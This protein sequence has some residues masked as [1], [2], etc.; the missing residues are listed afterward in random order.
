MRTSTLS[1]SLPSAALLAA[2]CAVPGP[3]VATAAETAPAPNAAAA[4]APG[5]DEILAR[6]AAARGG[7]DR[8]QAVRALR[9]SGTQAA[10]S[11][12]APFTL[13]YARPGLFRL[14]QTLLRQAVTVVHDGETVWWVN[15]LYGIDWPVRTPE[16]DAAVVR[17]AADL[18][19]PLLG[20]RDKGNAVE[21]AG[22]EELD[23]SPAWKLRVRR[24][25][26]AEETWYLDPQTYLEVAR[27]DQTTDFGSPEEQWT[28]FSDFRPVQGLVLPHHVEM[29]YGIRN[30]IL[31]VAKVEVD[32][33]V[34]PARFRLPLPEG[35]AALGAHGGARGG[36]VAQQPDPRA[37]AVTTR[38]AAT[39]T[40]LLG[41][42]ALEERLAWDDLGRPVQVVRT[43]SWDR[44]R[45]VYRLSQLDDVSGHL[46]VYEGSLADGKL[47]A[48]NAE[49][50][51]AM[52]VEGKAILARCT[53]S[54][55]G[56]EGFRLEWEASQ[57]DGK[58]WNPAATFTYARKKS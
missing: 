46:D 26:G 12:T 14:E 10:F 3:S 15:P 57:D 47:T 56:P 18:E 33:A 58:T 5:L 50:R 4:P 36:S 27:F 55:L 28:Y 35:M 29:E 31:D 1:R 24:R 19:G 2:L 37:P 45:K 22:L 32:P 25:D 51:T 21:L 7:L 20:A 17:R 6:H 53:L 48:S 23:G 41:G 11:E 8:W 40:P 49:T 39:I 30:V 13:T 44:F 52:A 42:T 16:P 38:T 43:W 54:G 9:L 34:D